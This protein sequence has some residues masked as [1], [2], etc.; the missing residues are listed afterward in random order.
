MAGVDGRRQQVFPAGAVIGRDGHQHRAFQ[1]PQAGAVDCVDITGASRNQLGGFLQ[2]IVAAVALAGQ[3]QDQVLLGARP[4]QMLQL[5]LLGALVEFQGD[6]QARVLVFQIQCRQQGVIFEQ[7]VDHQQVTAQQVS[8]VLL[9]G[10]AHFQQVQRAGGGVQG[11]ADQVVRVF[12]QLV[13]DRIMQL[14]ARFRLHQAG[15]GRADQSAQLHGRQAELAFAI[16][17]K[18]QQRP[19]CFIQP[20]ETQH[21]EPRGHRQ[22]RHY[23]GHHTAGGIGLAFHGGKLA[24]NLLNAP[25]LSPLYCCLPQG[26]IIAIPT[27]KRHEGQVL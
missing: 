3:Q 9:V 5:F 17:I 7:A 10:F 6:L 20:F 13:L 25:G 15:V 8:I 11:V 16:G 14:I 24:S 12:A 1:V 2:G 23:L 4:F 19:A 21:A 26:C 22:L 18:K 27:D